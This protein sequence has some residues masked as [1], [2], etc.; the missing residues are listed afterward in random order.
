MSTIWMPTFLWLLTCMSTRGHSSVNKSYRLKTNV[1][2]WILILK[3]FQTYPR[4]KDW[5]ILSFSHSEAVNNK[6]QIQHQCDSATYFASF[7]AF[8]APIQVASCVSSVKCVND[9][10]LESKVRGISW[11]IRRAC[12]EVVGTV[13][14]NFFEARPGFVL[15]LVKVRLGLPL[16]TQSGPRALIKTLAL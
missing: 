1:Y 2:I 15:K 4:G 12:F 10:D 5:P 8:T 11:L 7:S 6:W 3:K 16:K 13:G 9:P 14:R